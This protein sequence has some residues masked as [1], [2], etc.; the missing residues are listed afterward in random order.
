VSAAV[1]ISNVLYAIRS[2]SHFYIGSV[3]VFVGVDVRTEVDGYR[4]VCCDA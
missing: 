1:D 4:I 3:G 2:L